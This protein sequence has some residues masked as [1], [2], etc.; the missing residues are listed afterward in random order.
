MAVWRL[1]QLQLTCCCHPDAHPTQ[2][3][4]G[5]FD[6]KPKRPNLAAKYKDEK[7]GSS[8]PPERGWLGFMHVCATSMVCQ[9]PC[10][11]DQ[12]ELFNPNQCIFDLKIQI[13]IINAPWLQELTRLINANNESAVASKAQQ[14]GGH[15]AVVKAPVLAPADQKQKSKS[16]KMGASG[17]WM[18]AVLFHCK[19]WRFRSSPSV[20]LAT[21][22]TV[23]S[24]LISATSRPN[25]V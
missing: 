16:A 6:I 22:W 17:N 8:H 21:A 19:S 11:Q 25:I 20:D 14:S 23:C 15:L 2:R 7:V 12:V 4:A 3:P 10:C 13:C 18:Q 1:L 9:Q 5:K 24:G